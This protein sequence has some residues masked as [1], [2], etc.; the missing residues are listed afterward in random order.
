M[1]E[2]EISWWMDKQAQRW[3][4][5]ELWKRKLD[6]SELSQIIKEL[7]WWWELRFDLF[8]CDVGQGEW[9]EIWGIKP[10]VSSF[11]K[12]TLM[13]LRMSNEDT[14][15]GGSQWSLEPNPEMAAI[16]SGKVR[17]MKGLPWWLTSKR[18][19]LQCRRRR[20][21]PW[22]GKI[23]RGRKWQTDPV[24]LPWKLHDKRSLAGYSPCGHKRGR[25][26]VGT[27]QQQLL[28]GEWQWRS[29]HSPA[30][31]SQSMYPTNGCWGFC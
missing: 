15:G 10:W 8:R 1:V 9:V 27:K 5:R 4:F 18:I 19:H 2:A 25:H 23:P 26:D 17:N 14:A 20:F 28:M 31:R 21:D 24:L 3:Q 6:K 29:T 30:I 7:G 13:E 11:R 22:V 12:N 16:K